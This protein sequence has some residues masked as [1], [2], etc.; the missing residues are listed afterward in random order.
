MAAHVGDGERRA[1]PLTDLLGSLV[2]DVTL[3]A[4]HEGELAIIELKGK[5]TEVGIGVGV[6]ACGALAAV[7]ALAAAIAAAVLGLA[8]V[9]PA[10]AAAL[11]VAVALLAAAAALGVLGRA[12]IRAAAPLVPT[13][14]L[15]SVQEDIRWIRQ[16]MDDLNQTMSG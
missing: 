11:I 13:E 16:Q 9:L 10:W 15:E 1:A 4:R 6:L 5:A 7:F 2:T 3:L 12:R 14:T 8:I